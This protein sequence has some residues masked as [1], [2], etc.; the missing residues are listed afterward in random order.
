MSTFTITYADG[1]TSTQTHAGPAEQLFEQLF[2]ACSEE[3]RELC[4]VVK[5]EVPEADT[6][7]KVEVPEADT[8]EKPA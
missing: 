4:T 6:A 2:S 8:S 5:V 1:S 3:V 7:V